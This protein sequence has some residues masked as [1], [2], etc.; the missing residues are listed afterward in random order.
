MLSSTGETTSVP[1]SNG[2]NPVWPPCANA[3]PAS[4]SSNKWFGG[5]SFTKRAM[6]F[7]NGISSFNEGDLV[8]L[9]ERGDSRLR[10]GE[11]R[12]AQER[13][14][15]FPRQAANLRARPLAENHLADVLG[16]VQQLVNGT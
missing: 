8:D 13:H 11:R 3:M 12:F 1:G 15:F 4:E 5:G 6:E 9:L 16:K 7:R 14:A 10:L 2:W